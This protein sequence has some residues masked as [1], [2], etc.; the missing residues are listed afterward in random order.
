MLPPAED[1]V[2]SQADSFVAALPADT[3]GVSSRRTR[4]YHH[5]LY[6][7]GTSFLS[8]KNGD[9]QEILKAIGFRGEESSVEH[10]SVACKSVRHGEEI[11]L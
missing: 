11:E 5:P 9:V 2:G 8:R 4:E 7:G 3:I 1:T 10:I 6:A